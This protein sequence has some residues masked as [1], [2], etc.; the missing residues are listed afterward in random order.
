MHRFFIAS[1][2]F[3]SALTAC[4]GGG[5]PSASAQGPISVFPVNSVLTKLAIS[6]GTFRVI[7]VDA[8]GNQ[9]RL[10]V[11]Y[12]P[13]VSGWF[14]RRQTLTPNGSSGVTTQ[15]SINFN[16]TGTLFKVIGWIDKNSNNA[17][18]GESIALPETSNIGTS[19][20]L[21]SGAILIQNNGINTS[22]IGL[23]H[24]LSY[25]WRLSAVNETTAELCV[26]DWNSGPFISN[27]ATDCFRIDAV[28]TILGFRSILGYYAKEA[29]GQTVYQ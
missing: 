17:V 11:D 15:E 24:G 3:A 9:I 29:N 16:Q 28:G 4:G 19:G 10:T 27:F 12:V 14:S 20:V 6:G 8:N 2:V 25:S 23:T 1:I 5:S 18:I 21:A 13:G 22:D 26:I 7:N